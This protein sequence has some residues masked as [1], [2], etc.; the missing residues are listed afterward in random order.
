MMKKNWK[1]IRWGWDCIR[2]SDGYCY[3]FMKKNITNENAII[4]IIDACEIGIESVM[5]F[6]DVLQIWVCWNCVN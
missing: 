3:K 6:G 4:K 5:A 1:Q 2:F